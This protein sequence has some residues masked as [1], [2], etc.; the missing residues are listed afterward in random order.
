MLPRRER[1]AAADQ[2]EQRRLAGAVR[3]DD[4]VAF[5]WLA[6]ARSTPLM[7]AVRPKLL[8]TARSSR[9]GVSRVHVWDL[10]LQLDGHLR[11]GA[12]DQPQRRQ[13]QGQ[14]EGEDEWRPRSSGGRA[15]T[16]TARP[17]SVNCARALLPPRSDRSFRP[18]R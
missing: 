1:E 5:A 6:M 9:A 18:A 12:P 4:G 10:G 14:A 13:E 16:L 3:T 11:P 17:N 8:W 2:V 15:S 7:I